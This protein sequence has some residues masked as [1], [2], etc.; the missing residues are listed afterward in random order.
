M[1]FILLYIYTYIY[2]YITDVIKYLCRP[3]MADTSR[4]FCLNCV[5]GTLV[6]LI[7]CTY[8]EHIS[9]VFQCLCTSFKDSHEEYTLKDESIIESKIINFIYLLT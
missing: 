1:Y 6:P 2:I 7:A 9:Q 4:Y 3:K 5:K 8:V